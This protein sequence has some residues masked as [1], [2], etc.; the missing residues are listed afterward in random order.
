MTI[1]RADVADLRPGDVVELVH[2]DWP[3]GTKLRG[4]VWGDR[5]RLHVGSYIVRDG[6]ALATPGFSL[7]VISRAP[8]P[9]YVNHDR[10]V[11]VLGDVVRTANDETRHAMPRDATARPETYGTEEIR[12]WGFSSEFSEWLHCSTDYLSQPL[13]LLVDGATGQAV[14]S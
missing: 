10:P 4:P 5:G 2:D 3:A 13:T 7:T 9:I 14:P 12:W 8:R 1:T 6:A 11:P